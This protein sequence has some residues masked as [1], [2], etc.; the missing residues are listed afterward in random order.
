MDNP[1][2]LRT[3]V[4]CV[5]VLTVGCTASVNQTAKPS[6]TTGAAE[7]SPGAEG[8]VG[9][10][11]VALPSFDAEST[12]IWR[13]QPTMLTYIGEMYDPLIA[14]DDDG[15]FTHDGIISDW[16]A[17][18][19]GDEVTLKVRPGVKFHNGD[20][21]TAED[22]KF[23]FEL[24]FTPGIPA[25]SAE[26][27][28]IVDRVEVVDKYTAQVI[29]KGPNSFFPHNL[30]WVEGDMAVLPKRYFESLPGAT[31]EA[32]EAE[33]VKRPIGTGPY[34]F[35]KR[36][37]GVSIE[38]VANQDYYDAKRL[39]KFERLVLLVA[40]EA[41]TRVNMLRTGQVDLASLPAEQAIQV[42]GDGFGLHVAK[43]VGHVMVTFPKSYDPSFLTNNTDFRK[44]LVL[45]VDRPAVASAIWPEIP[46]SGPLGVVADA[47][48]LAGPGVAGYRPDLPSY[49]YDPDEARR[50]LEKT[51]YAKNPQTVI[52][53]AS[54]FAGIEE[55]PRVAQA[56]AGYW[57][58]VGVKVEI[59]SLDLSLLIQR[60]GAKPQDV[61]PP[62]T[63]LIA[64]A[65]GLSGI[66]NWRNFGSVKYGFTSTYFDQKYA[67]QSFLDLRSTMDPDQFE[68]KMH[69][70]WK[71]TAETYWAIPLVWRGEVWAF[72]PKVLGDWKP[73]N[74]GPT[75]LRFETAVPASSG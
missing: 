4:V 16:Q 6:G 59:Q 27:S 35:E 36:E 45:A 58:A 21:V 42:H 30:A 31:F 73:V 65:F 34:K 64:T 13:G 63:A 19:A 41:T 9:T 38:F 62:A 25:H 20:E 14:A 70:L 60:L 8:P 40:G 33:F 49:P 66:N 15:Q 61:D 22:I 29:L 18:P 7:Q 48:P 24:Y 5:L 46:G 52:I 32:K 43:N 1:R 26:L 74:G 68:E 23:T 71:T 28:T 47:P 72:D 11:R 67:D 51:G 12:A 3:A 69:E 75:Y 57:E 55:A 50:L 39:P 37:P 17:N 53:W 2:A 56:I 44:A 10:L 54:V